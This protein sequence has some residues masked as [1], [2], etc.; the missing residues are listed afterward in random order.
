M[1]VAA[2]ALT[3]LA[4]FKEAIGVPAATDSTNDPK[5]ERFINRA[6]DAIENQTGRKLKA[7][8]YDGGSGTHGTTGVADEDYLYFSGHT[9]D[10]GGDTIRDENGYGVLHLPQ[11]PVEAN[12]VVVFKLGVLVGRDDSGVEWDDTQ[13]L[14]NRDFLLDRKNGVIRLLG[15]VFSSGYQNYRITCSAGYSTVPGDLEELCIEMA[16]KLLKNEGG[17]TSESIDSWSKSYDVK[18]ASSFIDATLSLYRRY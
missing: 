8:H 11:Y 5:Y 4:N 7:R 12:S 16:K 2:N 10:R 15:G 14:E 9:L 3:S 18:A 1:A 6:S 17:V 13:L